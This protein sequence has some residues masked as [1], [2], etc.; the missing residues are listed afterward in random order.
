VITH[1]RQKSKRLY[2]KAFGNLLCV[3]ELLLTKNSV[4]GIGRAQ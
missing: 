2:E 3:S 4:Y 1:A